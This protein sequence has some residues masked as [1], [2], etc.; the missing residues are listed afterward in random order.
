[1]R[2]GGLPLPDRPLDLPHLPGLILRTVIGDRRNS[3]RVRRRPS[4]G[5]LR[6][7]WSPRIEAPC[8]VVGAPRSG[9]TFLGSCLGRT[10]GI[11]YHFEPALTK[12]AAPYVY[13]GLWDD[14]RS[15][16]FFCST[17]RWLARLRSDGDLQFVEKTPRNAMLVPFLARTFPDSRFIHIVRDGRDVALSWSERPW[18]GGP[19][20]IR[21]KY[22]PGGYRYGPHP[23]MWVESGRMD[24]SPGGLGL[25][26]PCRGGAR[27]R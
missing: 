27:R 25:A 5:R 12:A 13:L 14:E 16:R 9:T 4:V 20:T 24:E 2:D 10:P 8:F 18:L 26:P 3:A 19:V 7:S 11:S 6:S 17:Y 21:R 1:M 23:R 15:A 22:E